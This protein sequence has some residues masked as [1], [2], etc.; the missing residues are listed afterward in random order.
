MSEKQTKLKTLKEMGGIAEQEEISDFVDKDSIENVV[1]QVSSFRFGNWGKFKGE[2]VMV[3]FPDNADEGKT[4]AVSFG[5][6]QVVE[7]FK[8]LQAKNIEPPFAVTFIKKLT[9][10]G[11]RE[12][13]VVE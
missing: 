4:K 7:T 12:Y 10:D 1:L 11:E 9:K 5:S 6:V 3:L 2:Q 8:G 13:W